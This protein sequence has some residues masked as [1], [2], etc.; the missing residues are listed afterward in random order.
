MSTETLVT[1]YQHRLDEILRKSVAASLEAIETGMPKRLA[2][3]SDSSSAL[4]E[5]ALFDTLSFEIQSTVAPLVAQLIAAADRAVEERDRVHQ[6]EVNRLTLKLAQLEAKMTCP[7]KVFDPLQEL[8]SCVSAGR[9]T[10][11][12]KIAVQTNVASFDLIVSRIDNAEHFFSANPIEDDRLAIDISVG[13]CKDM[14]AD[15]LNPLSM[16]KVEIINELVL[17]L[18]GPAEFSLLIQLM[19]QLGSQAQLAPPVVTR[20]AE[21]FT[22]VVATH[23]VVSNIGT[24]TPNFQ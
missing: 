20:L 5:K 24:P 2:K 9:W 3:P 12:F 21:V 18:S 8:N 22:I 13:L 14:L 16:T 4:L 19:G 17:N 1:S 6:A 10:D 23:R 15:P 7:Q 11:A